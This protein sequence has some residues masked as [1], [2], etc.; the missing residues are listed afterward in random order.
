MRPR[1][2]LDVLEEK[3]RRKEGEKKEKISSGVQSKNNIT[4][5]VMGPYFTRH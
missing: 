2:D 1:T 3:A 4:L 5:S